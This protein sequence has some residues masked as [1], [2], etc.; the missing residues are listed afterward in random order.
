M[1]VCGGVGGGGGGEGVGGGGGRLDGHY[2]DFLSEDLY[3]L[4]RAVFSRI[5]HRILRILLSYFFSPV[6]LL[7]CQSELII[8]HPK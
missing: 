6:L 8:V 5:L 1:C 3:G 7:R 4:I 2:K